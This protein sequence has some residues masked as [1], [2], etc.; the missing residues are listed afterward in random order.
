MLPHKYIFQI[1]KE[2]PYVFQNKFM[3]TL[4]II[5]KFL[6]FTSCAVFGEGS[7]FQEYAGSLPYSCSSSWAGSSH[8]WFSGPSVL[9]YLLSLH[10]KGTPSR[11]HPGLRLP[12]SLQPSR[13]LRPA[14]ESLKHTTLTLH[15]V[16]AH[17]VP[18]LDRWP[19]FTELLLLLL[20]LEFLSVSHSHYLRETHGQ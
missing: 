5:M 10:R 8:V 19:L 1:T 4:F 3:M 15:R 13:S 2:Q 12:S 7:G 17:A 16:S 18:S 11:P 6:V 20:T 14:P 9:H